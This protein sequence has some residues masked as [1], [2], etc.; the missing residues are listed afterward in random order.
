MK[1]YIYTLILFIALIG[2]N[3][4]SSDTGFLSPDI[5]LQGADTLVVPLGESQTSNNAYL[6]GST[7]PLEFS[8]ENIRNQDGERSQQF[9]ETYLTRSWETPYNHEEDTTLEQINEKLV[10]LEKTP[11]GINPVNGS[12]QF[13]KSTINLKEPGDVFDVDVRVKN[14]AGEQVLENYTTLKLSTETQPFKFY[15]ATTAIILLNENGESLFTLYDSIGEAD[16]QRHENIYQRNGKE[17]IDI[18]K[19]S[20][21]PTNGVRVLIQY[22]DAEGKIFDSEEYQTYSEGTESYFDHAV[23]RENTSEG[24]YVEFPITPWPVD[25]NLLSYLKGGTDLI[26]ASLDTASLHQEVYKEGKYP[27]LYEWP[28][29]SWGAER[30]YIR[31]R[32]KIVFNEPGTWVIS[33]E[34]PYTHI[35]GTF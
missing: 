12:I 16:L 28:D 14:T 24:A 27:Y 9:F 26:S 19:K 11:V 17:L 21:E 3:Q 10:E 18:Y 23:G 33:T 2:C 7:E 32:S 34:F 25:N 4:I 1:S 29:E 5:Y 20:D 8:I 22:K 31:L 6:D 13:L 35:D 15:R 30:W